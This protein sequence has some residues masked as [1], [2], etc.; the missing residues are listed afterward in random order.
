MVRAGDRLVELDGAISSAERDRLRSNLNAAMLQ[1]ARARAL[2][3]ALD[4]HV[5]PVLERMV[6]VNPELWQEAQRHLTGTHAE[7]LSKHRQS[8]VELTR[9]RA[10]IDSVR[11]QIA[12]IELTLPLAQEREHDHQVLLAQGHVSRYAWM[13]QQQ[14]V[15]EQQGD[16]Q[17][18]R[19]KLAEARAAL[20]ASEAQE[21]ALY[22]ETRRAQLDTLG[23]ALQKVGDLR[24]ELV[25]AGAQEGHTRL[26]SP[27]DGAVQQLMIHTVGGVVTP[28]Q[29]LM[30]VVPQDE[31]VVVEA[32]LENRDV[33]FVREGDRAEVKVDAFPY[34]RFGTVSARVRHVS[35][36]AVNDEKRGPIYSLL[37]AW[38]QASIMVDGKSVALT[39]GMAVTADIRTGS[40]RAIEYFLSPLL[41][42]A[43]E[44]LRER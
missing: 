23:E 9:R 14:H 37:L 10:E 38:D 7:Y 28:A 33:G 18:Q 30:L 19:S 15:L 41:E 36:D 42:Y 27:V 13:E 6:G 22:A 17:V 26:I 24:Q 39:P 25:K 32:T 5:P 34:T 8:Q 1:A 16:L 3:R 29:Q 20:I 4:Q 40:R 43:S 12:K 21:M 31:P 11:T 2:L 35:R 44:S